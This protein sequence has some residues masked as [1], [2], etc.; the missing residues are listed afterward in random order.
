MFV[1]HCFVIM[2]VIG[3]VLTMNMNMGMDVRMLVGMNNIAM[4]MFV[5]MG[6]C[7]LVCMLQF[8]GV[9]NHEVCAY[10]HHN[11]SKIKLDCRSFSQYQHAKRH[12]KE[13]SD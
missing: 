3:A 9:L 11:Q 1:R 7:M 6:V 12:A 10:D 8:D 13:W 4:A 5:R 2:I